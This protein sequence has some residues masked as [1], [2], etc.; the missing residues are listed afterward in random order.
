MTAN[1]ETYAGRVKYDAERAE[2]YKHKR[3]EKH[4]AEMRLID[5]SF[6]LVPKTHRV[7]DVPCG[8]GRVS[9]HLAGKGY[10][11]I[12]ADLSDAM[13]EATREAIKAAGLDCVVEQQDVERLSYFDRSFDTVLCFR[14]FHHFPS[15][16]IRRRV[17]AELCRVSS[18][19]VVL[20]YFHPS[21]STVQR[22]LRAKRADK[23]MNKY[24]TTLAE[25]ESY[26]AEAGFRL[27]KDFAQLRMIHTLHVAV[28]ERTGE[29]LR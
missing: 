28:F 8:T 13:R 25:V 22:K 2:R 10:R 18:K 5:R 16:E 24:A 19:F 21:L 17:I 15:A 12:P 1:S 26:F 11:I 7:L 9:L 20:S 4:R 23:P 3:P 6:A 27:V 14:L 29:D